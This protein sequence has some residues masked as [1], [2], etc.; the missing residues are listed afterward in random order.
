MELGSKVSSWVTMPL[1]TKIRTLELPRGFIT[2]V[3]FVTSFL[4]HA[5][6]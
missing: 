5:V 2:Q 1:L 3:S 4:Y 6:I